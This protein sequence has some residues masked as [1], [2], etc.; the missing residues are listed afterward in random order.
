MLLMQ[1]APVTVPTTR[2]RKDR[3]RDTLTRL[4]RPPE[5]PS[6]ACARPVR[7]AVASLPPA[8]A[9]RVL[10]AI[11]FTGSPAVA[12]LGPAGQELVDRAREAFVAGVGDA[13]LVGCI[14]LFIAAV[15]VFLIAGSEEGRSARAAAAIGDPG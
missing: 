8:I 13:V 7:P 5:E 2:V 15:L 12:Q 14:V 11:A 9:E 10:G 4:D 6:E 3:G 1:R